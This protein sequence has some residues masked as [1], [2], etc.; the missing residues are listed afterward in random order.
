MSPSLPS[1]RE[2]WLVD[3]ESSASPGER[4]KPACLAARE[5]RSGRAL[6]LG[7]D[8]LG[9]RREAPYPVDSG[10]LF[11]AYH[12]PVALGCHLALGWPLPARILHLHAEFRVRTNGLDTP[13]GAGL[14]GASAWHGLDVMGTAGGAALR[15]LAYRGGPWSGSE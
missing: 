8:D 3:V 2:A 5:L 7:P 12:S 6:R 13:H 10:S 1:F 15:A 11:V 14:L 4:P 9:G